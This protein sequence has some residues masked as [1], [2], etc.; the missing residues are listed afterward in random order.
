MDREIEKIGLSGKVSG[1]G[2][3]DQEVWGGRE[4]RKQIFRLNWLK[5]RSDHCDD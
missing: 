5:R 2:I 3:D 1:G 4:Q